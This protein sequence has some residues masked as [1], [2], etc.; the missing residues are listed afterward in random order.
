MGALD[1]PLFFGGGARVLVGF[2]L[3][4]WLVIL[5]YKVMI[6]RRDRFWIKRYF[7]FERLENHKYNFEKHSG[8]CFWHLYNL[9]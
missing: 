5:N 4:N 2:P 7:S 1:L 6:A 9:L 3:F 8:Y